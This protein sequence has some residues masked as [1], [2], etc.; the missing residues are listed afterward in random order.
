M[1]KNPES[2]RFKISRHAI[3]ARMRKADEPWTQMR[4]GQ[5]V[6]NLE[7]GE[8]GTIFR[9]CDDLVTGFARYEVEY[10][11]DQQRFA[12]RALLDFEE[13]RLKNAAVKGKMAARRKLET[14]GKSPN[15]RHAYTTTSPIDGAET[16]LWCNSSR[17][18][19]PL[20]EDNRFKNGQ[21]PRD[22]R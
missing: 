9:S 5:R 22:A 13:R 21:S 19:P 15:G 2:P 11:N 3:E 12:I 7:T 10:D 1:N 4:V 18:C 6:I 8:R 16:C 14:C 20:A 17:P